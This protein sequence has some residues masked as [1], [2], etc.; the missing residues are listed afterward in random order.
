MICDKCK[1]PFDATVTMDLPIRCPICDDHRQPETI[2]EIIAERD[3]LRAEVEP[4]RELRRLVEAFASTVE[5]EMYVAARVLDAQDD[6]LAQAR[7][8][9]EGEA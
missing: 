8:M 7:K 1:R 4:L 3:R 9:R 2:G 6:L 5:S